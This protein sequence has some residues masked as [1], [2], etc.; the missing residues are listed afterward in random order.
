[1]ANTIKYQAI[2]DEK[3]GFNADL[4][5]RVAEYFSSN[6][7]SIH[8][9]IR[10]VGK[11][12][13]YVIASVCLYFLIL[14]MPMHPALLLILV[15]LFGVVNAGLLM[16]IGHDALH[17]AYSSNNRLNRFLG[18]ILDVYGSNSYMW[19]VKH[20][21]VHHSHTNIDQYDEDLDIAPGLIRIREEDDWNWFIRYQHYYAF[22]LYGLGPILRV[23]KQ[24]YFKFFKKNIGFLDNRP[25]PPI[26]Y[27]NLFFFKVLYY[28]LFIAIPIIVLPYAWWAVFLGFLLMLFAEGVILGLIFQLAHYV[29]NVEI[30]EAPA[31]A[32]LEG[33]WHEYQ[34]RTTS[35]FAN[36]NPIVNFL[37][38]GLNFQIEHHLF[39][40]IC[41]IHYKEIKPIV[42]STAIEHGLPYID[43][44]SLG[45]AIRQHNLLLKKM[46][47][48]ASQR[49]SELN[50]AS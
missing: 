42:R 40:Q 10:M 33:T 22:V 23:F 2:S 29:D 35:N 47:K 45:D 41:H 44:H 28:T 17:N 11:S 27:F 9:D 39:P 1:M 34:M 30:I 8:A 7:K 4:Q 20:N 19:T 12:L 14:F 16:N 18:R 43:N 46:S 31:D 15:I 3:S 50:P 13:F 38:G 36:S 48:P 5:A 25:H 37:A 26:E 49:A 32:T 6:G 24:D 21:V